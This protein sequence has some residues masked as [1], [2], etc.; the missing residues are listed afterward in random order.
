MMWRSPAGSKAAFKLH[1]SLQSFIRQ[2]GTAEAAA[3]AQRAGLLQRGSQAVEWTGP[4]QTGSKAVKWAAWPGSVHY[5]GGPCR[6]P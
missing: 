3:H 4:L 2:P 5:V 1:G 6:R